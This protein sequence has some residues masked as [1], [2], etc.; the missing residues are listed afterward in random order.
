MPSQYSKQKSQSKHKKLRNVI[1]STINEHY[2]ISSSQLHY[3]INCIN[4]NF[5][6]YQE[7]YITNFIKWH[8]QSEILISTDLCENLSTNLNDKSTIVFCPKNMP[9]NTINTDR[10]VRSRSSLSRRQQQKI[11]FDGSEFDAFVKVLS[12]LKTKNGGPISWT[13]IRTQYNKV[14]GRSLTLD[15]LNKIANTN[16]LTRRAIIETR[17]CGLLSPY[18]KK[19][20]NVTINHML[21]SGD[22]S[23][24]KENVTPVNNLPT[25]IENDNENFKKLKQPL[26]YVKNNHDL[27]MKE[28]SF[29]ETEIELRG[30]SQIPLADLAQQFTN[31]CGMKA[32]IFDA[33]NYNTE[34]SRDIIISMIA[35]KFKVNISDTKEVFL[36]SKDLEFNVD[37]SEDSSSIDKP[38]TLEHEK[39][40]EDK[41]EAIVAGGDILID[42]SDKE[43]ESNKVNNVYG[44]LSFTEH[45]NAIGTE[46]PGDAL[47]IFICSRLQSLIEEGME[48]IPID[49]LDNLI[50]EFFEM[51]VD[52]VREF[53]CSW[54]EVAENFVKRNFFY[55]TL[56]KKGLVLKDPTTPEIYEEHVKIPS[57]Y[58]CSSASDSSNASTTENSGE[59]FVDVSPASDYDSV[60]DI[61]I[62]N[63]ENDMLEKTLLQTSIEESRKEKFEEISAKMVNVFDNDTKLESL[64][65]I[66][67]KMDDDVNDKSIIVNYLKEDDKI[68]KEDNL[69]D[70]ITNVESEEKLLLKSEEIL[71]TTLNQNDVDNKKLL[72]DSTNRSPLQNS[73]VVDDPN[74]KKKLKSKKGKCCCCTIC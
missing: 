32:L 54:R 40:I 1:L 31:D 34:E 20:D 28:I 9:T 33:I 46:D 57:D 8:L 5:T 43:N 35:T 23:F 45:L 37:I 51:K 17:F 22:K 73:P 70:V 69:V 48:S 58:S 7:D 60:G 21:G 14:T 26:D 3:R 19:C 2:P 52:P 59:H 44:E 72:D 15:E 49:N 6:G 64:P 53:G 25:N 24:N 4:K 61:D 42:D 38:C 18:D 41:L 47:E 27:I 55:Y 66:D 39:E 11:S 62:L 65:T 67:I 74:Q 56:D 36:S 13:K 71:E 50:N 30:G 29:Y 12:T 68:I 16:G 63:E 10:L